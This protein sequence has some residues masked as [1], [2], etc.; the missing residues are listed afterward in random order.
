MQHAFSDQLQDTRLEAEANLSA[1]NPSTGYGSSEEAVRAAAGRHHWRAKVEGVEYGG[2]VYSK[3]VDGRVR[4]FNSDT[5]RG[6]RQSVDPLR[7]VSSDHAVVADWHSHHNG[8][9][10][11]ST[12]FSN[13]I[14]RSDMVGGQRTI[15]QT[16]S[17][18]N[19]ARFGVANPSSQYRFFLVGGNDTLV[20][21]TFAQD[22]WESPQSHGALEPLFR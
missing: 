11:F 6:G 16:R 7:D 20:S 18:L 1:Q 19:V 4:Y 3:T 12:D 13:D 10:V 22:L 21:T 17:G 8:P 14:Y 15:E 5:V 9:G 2:Y